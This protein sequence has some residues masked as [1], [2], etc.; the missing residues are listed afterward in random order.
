M[1]SN[2][3]TNHAPFSSFDSCVITSDGVKVKCFVWDSL[4]GGNPLT[5]AIEIPV[6]K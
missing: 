4:E 2:A 5:D 3:T 6:V 1:N